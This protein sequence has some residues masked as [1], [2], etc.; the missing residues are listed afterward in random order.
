MIDE[1]FDR[2]GEAVAAMD[3]DPT[4]RAAFERLTVLATRRSA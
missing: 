2:C 3:L 1:R 4:T